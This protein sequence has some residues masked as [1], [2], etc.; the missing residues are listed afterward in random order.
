VTLAFA[1]LCLLA[2]DDDPWPRFAPRGPAEAPA[3]FQARDGFR[4]EL[5]AAEPLVIDPVAAAY[6]EDGRLYV[7]EMSDY[8]YADKASDRPFT[9]NTTDPPLGRVRLLTDR[10]GDGRFDTATVLAEKLS[11]PTGVAVWK[12][13]VFVAATPDIWYLKDTDDDG[14]ADVRQRVLTGFRKFNIQAVMNNLIWG[15]DHA[16]HGA[17]SGNGGEVRPADEPDA[18]PVSVLR[19][20][21]RFDP[22]S[23]TLE[24]ISGGARFGN[25]FDDWGN[26]FLCDIRNP[27]EHVV[28]PA[29]YLD[30]NP[31]LPPIRPLHDAAESGDQIP[32]Y[33]ISPPE[34]W[35]ELR[36]RRWAAIGKKLPRSEL[37]GAGVL[38]SS[39]GVT[40]YRGD[41]Y[42]AE[43][44]GNLFLGEVANNVVHR[45]VVEPDGVTFR[46]HRAPGEE[47]A[48]FVASTDT[49]F[50]PVNFVNAPDGTLTVL[51]MYRETIEHPWSIPDDIKARLDLRSGEDRGRI[52]RL[53]PPGFHPRPAPRLSLATTAE[54]VALLE[55]P[56]AWHRDSAHRLI[57]ERQDQAAVEPLRRLLRESQ[58]PL[59]RLHALWS[60]EGL[61]ALSEGD[62][63]AALIDPAEGVREHAVRLAEPRLKS[64]TLL[65][66]EVIAMA[67]DPAIRVRFQ[68]ALSLGEAPAPRTA[69]PLARIGWRD[70]R[71]PW[72]RSAILSSSARNPLEVLAALLDQAHHPDL[73]N[74]DSGLVLTGRLAFM[75]GARGR[76]DEVV[77]ALDAIDGDPEQELIRFESF[78]EVD[79]I[80]ELAEG[81]R[82]SGGRLFDLPIRRPGHEATA[83]LVESIVKLAREELADPRDH[84][85]GPPVVRLFAHRPFAEARDVLS[86]LLKPT[87]PREFQLEAVRT[88]AIFDETAVA[89]ILLA[90]W[91]E[92]SPPV[93]SEVLQVLLGR[94]MWAGPLLDAVR[95]GTVAPGEIPTARW[96]AL[97]ASPDPMVR[98]KATAL[99]GAQAPGPRLK[100]IEQY[101]AV[102]S[103][104]A[105]PDRGRAVFERECVACHKL[106]EKGN[107]VGPNLASIQ[108][109]T[110]DEL[111]THILDPNREVAPDF[112]EYLVASKTG[113]VATGLIETDSEAGITLKRAEGVTES[114]LRAEIDEVS[115]T[116][117]SLMPEGLESKI[118]PQEM[119]DLIAFLLNLQSL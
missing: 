41:A 65:R 73:L 111:L 52:Y 56:N 46:A 22:A 40:V 106:G 117:R 115:S 79:L 67:E 70:A 58:Y 108:R 35:R 80:I 86:P 20:D 7:V 47:R 81:F 64:S 68:V 51:D 37:V 28:L 17:A 33:R 3:T 53:A 16:I 72:V 85:V 110:P 95:A 32:I 63:L 105:D 94:P 27:A 90:A 48:E 50:R 114:I 96:S 75:V 4:M 62:L 49:W 89:A 87:T 14:T 60:L 83:D 54:L 66:Q 36:A 103:R 39:S 11:W 119:C 74:R 13:G 71:D 102:L 29:R 10:D 113:R 59:G 98:E 109:R 77:R 118:S 76:A 92:Y 6:D 12:G 55:H 2:A 69:A 84:A 9:E 43:F 57:H 30:R 100:V 97:M 15:L 61:H 25:T 82:R 78:P 8:P 99:F 101:T 104:D 21:F 31:Y 19:R 42:P 1:L 45:M 5:L 88:L 34:P 112:I 23:H 38:T 107:A 18:K 24:A 44:R 26:R 93:R 91:K 116:G